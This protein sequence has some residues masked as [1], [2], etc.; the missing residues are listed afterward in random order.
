ME[1]FHGKF[2]QIIPTIILFKFWPDYNSCM[3]DTRISQFA[4]EL[5]QAEIARS[6][7]NE[8]RSRVCCRRAAGI[9]IREYF[10]RRGEPVPEKSAY[11]LLLRLAALPDIPPEVKRMS[12]HLTMRV[13]EEFTLPIDVDLIEETYHLAAFLL[14]DWKL[15]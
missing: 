10:S 4:D 14:S 9:A 2:S 12:D 15:G 1:F 5:Q 7:G 8:G 6:H 3:S 11:D 13:T